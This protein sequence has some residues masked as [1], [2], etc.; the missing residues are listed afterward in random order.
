MVRRSSASMARLKHPTGHALT[1]EFLAFSKPR[2][3][4]VVEAKTTKDRI[5]P[6]E[7]LWEA[8]RNLECPRS[9]NS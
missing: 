5:S 3:S 6:L 7:S 4:F 2:T 9:I 8:W 1:D